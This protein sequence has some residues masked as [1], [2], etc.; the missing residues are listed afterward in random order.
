MTGLTGTFV[1][2]VLLGW[3][4]LKVWLSDSL[5]VSHSTL[6]VVAGIALLLLSSHLFRRPLSSPL[7]LVP[8][9]VLELANE[10]MDYLRY[11]ADSW[12]WTWQPSTIEAALTLLP[13]L[14]IVATARWRRRRPD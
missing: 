2:D 11:A 4:W 13:P 12:P 8:I 1:Y 14:A 3:E 6:H 10:A 7:L 9:F 5:G